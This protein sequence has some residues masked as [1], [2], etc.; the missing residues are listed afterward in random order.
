MPTALKVGL[1]MSVR[2]GFFVLEGAGY[3]LLG[4]SGYLTSS[5]E[6]GSQVNENPGHIY[7]TCEF[8]FA[9]P[10]VSRLCNI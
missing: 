10:T 3:L 9:L 1:T 2:R 7:K 4:C 6:V 8:D 5:F